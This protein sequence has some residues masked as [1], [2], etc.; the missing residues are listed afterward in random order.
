MIRMIPML[1]VVLG[2]WGCAG[3]WFT[4][5]TVDEIQRSE[6]KSQ[7]VSAKASDVVTRCMMQVLYTHTNAA[8]ARPFADVASQTYGTTQ[9]ITLRTGVNLA[10]KMYGGGDE[11]LFLIENVGSPTGTTST[12]WVHQR[13]WGGTMTGNSQEYLTTLNGVVRACL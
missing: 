6:Y 12:I 11:L 9:A 3:E 8:G 1:L 7:A 2:L 5:R 13:L 4:I 10:N